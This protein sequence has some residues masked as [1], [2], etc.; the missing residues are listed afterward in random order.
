MKSGAVIK[1]NYGREA[2]HRKYGS[3]EDM[4]SILQG[5]TT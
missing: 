2:H 1:D 5:A 3:V 4:G